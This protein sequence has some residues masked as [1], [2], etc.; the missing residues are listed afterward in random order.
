MSEHNQFELLKTRR[1]LPFFSTQFAGA[2]NDNLFK[3]AV[4]V[5]IVFRA[6]ENADLLVNIIAALFILP[7]FL[8]SATAG[9]IAEKLEKSRVIRWVKTAEIGIMLLGAVAFHFGHVPTLI[10]CIFLMGCHSTFFGPVKY[11]ILPQVLTKSELVGG[12]GLIESGTFLAILLGTIAG[13]VAIAMDA[14]PHIAGA[15]SILVAVLGWM[16]ARFVPTSPATAPNLKLN[17]NIWGET[18]ATVRLAMRVRAVWL[19]ILGISWFWALGAAYLTQ[20]PNFTRVN[21]GGTEQVFTVLMA[22]FSIGIGIGSGLCEKLSGRQVEIGLVPFGSLGLC[23]FGI[24]LLF[25]ASGTWSGPLRGAGAFLADPHSW[26]VMADL[27]L[28]GIFGGFYCVP[29]YALVQSRTDPEI[30][31]RVIAANNIVNAVFMVGSAGFAVVMLQVVGLTIPQFFLVMALLNIVA[32]I[33]IYSL[34]PEFLMRFL[35]WLLIS[36]IYR[37]RARGLEHIPDEGPALVVCNHVSYVDALVIGGTCRRPIRFVMDHQIFRIPLLN[38]VFRTA[39]AIPIAPQREHPAV[40]DAAFRRVA[41]Y[42]KDGEVVGIF[43]EGKLTRDGEMNPFRPGI[44]RILA[45]TPVIVVPM[46]LGNLWGSLFSWS[47][48]RAFL[49]RPRKFWAL[50]DLAVGS[51]LQPSEATPERLQGIVAE[52]RGGR[53]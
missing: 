41:Q 32:A 23:V 25:G 38:F 36:T 21:L 16:A 11:S 13:G 14:G 24:D 34:V 3:N 43:P 53:R 5:F 2:F 30:C 44:T 1:F 7:F 42:L 48:G 31:S 47:G 4:V 12:N 10:F 50:I 17:W 45:E 46:A 52:L 40:H 35:I 19:S 9:Q 39:G 22:T 51:R 26:R 15:A 20:L 33:Y 28:I 8:F 49:K 6:A 29:L 18:M 37:V 27:A